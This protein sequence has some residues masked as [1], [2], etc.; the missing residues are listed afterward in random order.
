MSELAIET[1]Q[2]IPDGTTS[3]TFAWRYL[4]FMTMGAG[5]NW[6]LPTALVQEVPYF[7][8]NLP[9][10]LC[11][12]TYMN[13]T[14]NF[15]IIAL[16]LYMYYINNWGLIPYSQTVPVLL[17]VSTLGCFLTA[18]VYSITA[19]GASVMLYVC[20]AIGGTVGA[21]SSVIMNPFMTR[22]DNSYISAAR[23]GGSGLIL[24]TAL[25]SALQSPGASNPRFSV[26]AYFCIFGV[27]L[28]LPLLAYRHIT[29]S[30]IGLRTA[31]DSE[32]VPTDS[33]ELPTV[34]NPAHEPE[35]GFTKQAPLHS[36]SD[37]PAFDKESLSA[38]GPIVTDEKN[39][40][41]VG[42]LYRPLLWIEQHAVPVWLH[43]KMPWLRSTLPY[44]MTVGWVNFNTWGIICAM[45]P[46]AMA[47]ASDGNGSLNLSIAYQ[48]SA[49]LLVSGD[50]S[51]T[52]IKLPI[53][54]SVLAFTVL[55]FTIYAAALGAPGFSTAVSPALLIVT[56]AVER[57]LEAHVV[58]SAY[59]AIATD[60]PLQHRQA[61]S[62]AVGIS[63]QLSTTAGALL[64]TLV[65]SLLFNCGS[66]D[67][68]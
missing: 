3:A 56:F 68:D 47:N 22:F 31:S 62:R 46:F 6:V 25:L 61:A 20:C 14:N 23:S 7:E 41:H 4:L 27:V 34:M 17:V 59:R 5:A 32:A 65:V 12:A 53:F 30:K 9:E 48:L 51:T 28:M 37:L 42:L 43:E 38:I 24:V 26:S 39:V 40:K 57:F 35:D 63:D 60:M 33:L 15:G 64:S 29:A 11:I 50:L 18:G 52:V 10:G 19:G 58:T 45:V 1:K 54:P 36:V 8:N 44:M 13:A 21:L 55:V 66:G 2:A 16:T 49:F 67:D